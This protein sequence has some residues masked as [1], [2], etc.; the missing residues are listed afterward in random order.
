MNVTEFL[1]R[2]SYGPL[3]NLAM[4]ND[5][6]G[7]IAVA[8]HPALIQHVNDGLL[9]LHTKFILIENEVILELRE[10]VT[11]YVLDVANSVSAGA[12]PPNDYIRDTLAA[13]FGNDLIKI[14]AVYETGAC[15]LPLNDATHDDSLYTPK[16]NVLQVPDPIAGAP[17]YLLYQAKHPVLASAGDGYLTQTIELPDV[18]VEALE[19]F[20]ASKVYQGMNGQEHAVKAAEHLTIY[21]RICVDVTVKDL[22]NSSMSNTNTKFEQRGFK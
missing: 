14:L 20:V 2:L 12:A 8:K 11:S 10:D 1:A 9:R 17:L 7:T 21:E 5:G 13:P 16:F 18:L 15:Q 19:A 3:S 6:D 4:S 22:V